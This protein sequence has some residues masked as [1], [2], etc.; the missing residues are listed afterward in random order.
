MLKPILLS[1]SCIDGLILLLLARVT[2]LDIGF[3]VNS[4]LNRV[5]KDSS[6]IYG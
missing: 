3:F 2:P 4:G 5:N 1:R 6:V